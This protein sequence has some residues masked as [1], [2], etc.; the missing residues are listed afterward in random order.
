[1]LEVDSLKKGNEYKRSYLAKLWGYKSHKAIEKGIVTSKNNSNNI[2]LFVTNKKKSE[3]AQYNDH[4]DIE[5][6]LLYMDGTN[7]H[8]NDDRIINSKFSGDEVYLFYR[9]EGHVDF[10]YFGQVYLYS[11]KKN[12][13]KNNPSKFVFSINKEISIS[14]S[15]ACSEAICDYSTEQKEDDNIFLGTKEG[16]ER[17][18]KHKSY[19]R[20]LKNRAE[21]IKEHGTTCLVCGFNFN[22]FYGKD[23]AKDFIEVHHL[24]PL[25]TYKGEE[26]IINP[27]TDL[28]PVCANCHRMLHRKMDKTI[29]IEELKNFIV[30]NISS[31]KLS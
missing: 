16:Q 14:Y 2:I 30:D 4:F 29:T 18:V 9:E 7:S 25:H 20:N 1:M 27:K 8:T 19:E 21:A 26:T 24:K 6:S 23:L 31:K 3:L 11:Y 13:E 22:K 15:E 17:I 28:A 12:E 5:N 10:E